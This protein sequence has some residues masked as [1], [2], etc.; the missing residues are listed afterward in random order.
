V[1]KLG[2]LAA[3]ALCLFAAVNTSSA[4][5]KED[6][7]NIGDIL[8]ALAGQNWNVFLHGGVTGNGL[9]LLQRTAAGGER[10]LR[11]ENSWNVGGGIGVDLLKSTGV[12][13]SY[14]Y[15]SGDLS[16]LTDLG[17][18]SEALDVA[19]V[20]TLT[21]HVA[22]LELV[23]Y[24]TPAHSGVAPYA[25]VGLTGSWFSTDAASA[26]IRRSG[27]SSQFRW[28]GVT[29]FGVQFHVAHGLYTQLEASSHSLG[30][31]FS[32]RRSF[33]ATGGTTVDEPRRVNKTDYRL[34]LVYRF[35]NAT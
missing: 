33:T 26:S 16:F 17:T 25:A 32:G 20:S 14:T 34:V 18:G 19:K 15:S 6:A 30:N 8:G 2:Y 31:P 28:G 7:D 27:G 11:D 21:T 12:R 5:Q 4:Q 3:S 13:A 10:A 22:D 29:S 23:N 9:F 1:S 24:M 35:G